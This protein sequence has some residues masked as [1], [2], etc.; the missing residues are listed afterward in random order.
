METDWRKLTR[1]AYVVAGHLDAA[2]GDGPGED[3]PGE[4][5]SSGAARRARPPRTWWSR[6][7]AQVVAAVLALFAAGVVLRGCVADGA[8]PVDVP[9]AHATQRTAAAD[10]GPGTEAE[11]PGGEPAAGAGPTTSRPDMPDDGAGQVPDVPQEFLVVHVAG[12]VASPGLV[13]LPPGAR[14]GDAIDAAGGAV[15]GAQVD[16]VNLARPLVDGEQIRVPA[17]GEEAAPAADS[18]AG[19]ATDPGGGGAAGG[20]PSGGAGGPVDL[21]TADAATLD[22]LPGIGPALSARILE[23]RAAIGGFTSVEELDDVSGIGPV[24]MERLRPLVTVG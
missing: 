17:E 21:N 23:H 15:P 18:V 11:T 13:E 24:V 8:T 1:A 9:A 12:A 2:A 3:V 22:T 5:V 10:A 4:D 19:G 6:R 7:P 16:A 14:V 20:G